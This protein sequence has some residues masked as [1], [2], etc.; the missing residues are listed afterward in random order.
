MGV[1]D[2]DARELKKSKKTMPFCSVQVFLPESFGR[3]R[4]REAVT[5]GLWPMTEGLMSNR[6]CEAWMSTHTLPVSPALRTKIV[7]V[8]YLLIYLFFRKIVWLVGTV[9]ME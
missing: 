8:I 6:W 2:T 1:N 7:C 9:A 3:C 4:G 5:K